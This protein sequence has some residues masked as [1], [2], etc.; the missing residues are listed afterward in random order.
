VAGRVRLITEIAHVERH[1]VTIAPYPDLRDR[2]RFPATTIRRQH[3]TGRL[4][5]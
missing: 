3:L 2:G 4:L 5:E 1:Q